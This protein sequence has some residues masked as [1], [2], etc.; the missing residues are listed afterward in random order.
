M[1]IYCS[2]HILLQHEFYVCLR[3][4]GH[5]FIFS[6]LNVRQ[7]KELYFKLGNILIEIKSL[8]NVSAEPINECI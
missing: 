7:I 4:G 1:L 6:L 2:S 5:P 3:K 8:R